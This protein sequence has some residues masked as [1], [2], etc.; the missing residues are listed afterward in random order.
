[1]HISAGKYKGKK[2]AFMR[3]GNVRPVMSVVRKAFFSIL[4]NQIIDSNFLDVFAGT[5]IMSLEA[6]SRGA[7]FVHLVD[8]NKVSRNLLVKNFRFINEPYKFFFSEAKIFL[9]KSNLFYDFIYLDPPFDYS[10]K[11]KLLEIISKNDSLNKYAKVIIHYPSRENLSKYILSLSKY[12]SRRYGDSRLDFF[13]CY[14]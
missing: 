4:F 7:R 10:F 14:S 1:M 11:E 12:D 13:K 9:K 2:V 5:G 6:L 3:A 8:Y